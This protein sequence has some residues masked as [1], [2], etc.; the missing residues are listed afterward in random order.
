MDERTDRRAPTPTDDFDAFVSSSGPGLRRLCW[1]LTGDRSLGEDLAQAVL[2]KLWRQWTRIEGDRYAYARR[3]A[4][5]E[6]VSWKRR[7]AWHAERPTDLRAD[8]TPA[9]DGSPEESLDR[10][11]LERWLTGLSPRYRAV[12]VLRYLLDLS[13]EETAAVLG[14]SAGTVKSRT[15]R[16]LAQ[17]RERIPATA[18]SEDR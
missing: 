9:R 12:V 6:S 7:R 11:D 10:L 18:R 2:V 4:V 3:I 5:N 15:S 1:A 8:T 14:C 17:L 13:V 16:A